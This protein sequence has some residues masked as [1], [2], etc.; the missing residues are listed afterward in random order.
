MAVI[1]FWPLTDEREVVRWVPDVLPWV[2]E[3]GN[4]Y[5]DWF[6]GSPA[7]ASSALVEWMVRPSSEVFVGR[8]V[9]LKEGGRATGG[10]IALDGAR[11]RDCRR[12]DAVAAMGA[13]GRGRREELIERMRAARRLFAPVPDD[14][15]YLSKLGVA[16]AARRAGRGSQLVGAYV[17]RGETLGFRRFWLDVHAGNLPAIR[18]YR[19]AGFRVRSTTAGAGGDLTYLRMSLELDGA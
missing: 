15:F 7:E 5:Y 9:L 1:T 18:L 12:A 16:A 6:F 4:P 19:A 11:L 3:A 2:H 17:T 8:A 14:V 10:F 13:A